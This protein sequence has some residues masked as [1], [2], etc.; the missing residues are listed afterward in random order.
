[1]NGATAT[2]DEPPVRPPMP[3]S[4]D[5]IEVDPKTLDERTLLLRTYQRMLKVVFRV[6][7]LEG[8]VGSLVAWTKRYDDHR[9]AASEA[10]TDPDIRRGRRSRARRAATAVVVVLSYVA[11]A[12]ASAAAWPTV[13]RV[14]AILASP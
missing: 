9:L 12:I 5:D 6:N 8:E 13:K 11:V 10:P 3:P 4:D 14:A 2:S 1:M 7:R